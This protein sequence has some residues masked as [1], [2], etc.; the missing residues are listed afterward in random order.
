MTCLFAKGAFVI[1]LASQ[2]KCLRV[3]NVHMHQ[4]ALMEYVGEDHAVFPVTM[5]RLKTKVHASCIAI[6][7]CTLNLS[8]YSV[9]LG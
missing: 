5:Q 3:T 9:V 4:R 8:G 6:H 7:A 2:K 1:A